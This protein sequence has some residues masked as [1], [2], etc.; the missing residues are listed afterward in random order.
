MVN[1][2]SGIGLSITQEFV[3]LHGGTIE[4]ESQPGKGSTFIFR[5]PVHD[6]RRDQD[7]D[8]LNGLIAE[9]E[10][11]EES[12]LGNVDKPLLLLVEDHEDFRVYLKDNLKNQYTIIEA[13]NGKQA[14]EKA[15]S[16]VPDLI[17]SDVMMPE[18][19][20]V[21]LCKR[22]KAD[23]RTSHVPVILLTARTAQEQQIE[24]FQSGASDY[25]T[26]PFSFEILESRIQNLIN[27]RRI[28]HQQFQKHLDI[29]VSEIEV[30]S[31]DEKLISTAVQLVEDN[32]TNSNFSVEELSRMLGMSRVHLYKK[33]FSLTGKTPIEFIRLIRIQ[34][35]AQLLVKS[36]L[37][38]SEVA[39]Q[40]GFNYPKYFA[41]YF[42]D[43]HN[44]LPSEYAAVHRQKKTSTPKDS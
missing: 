37:N 44:M 24:G 10:S 38:V 27:Q 41:R 3:K 20:G 39:Y 14:F 30:A 8:E 33:L 32:L 28:G 2:G 13:A 40:V 17:V 36:D 9:S 43:V 19:N 34:R 5:L 21:E 26:K 4:V 11:T 7:D 16:V 1:Q 12:A 6:I 31:M 15:V 22:I 23:A 18:L 42:R 25:I 35:A 29:K